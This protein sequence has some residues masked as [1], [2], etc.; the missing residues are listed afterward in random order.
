M[1][2]LNRG[3]LARIGGR[4]QVWWLSAYTEASSV[5]QGGGKSAR[6]GENAS[7]FS[8]KIM[9]KQRDEAIDPFNLM[10]S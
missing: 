3:P 9:F 6:D 5:S 10:Q 4:V 2:E 8:A 7:R 1:V